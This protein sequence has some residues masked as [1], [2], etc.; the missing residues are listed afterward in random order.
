M[1]Y[2]EKEITTEG[3][4]KRRREHRGIKVL[5]PFF[6]CALRV[7]TSVPSVVIFSGLAYGC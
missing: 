7:F 2:Q 3:T 6:L 5:T 1:I 4:E